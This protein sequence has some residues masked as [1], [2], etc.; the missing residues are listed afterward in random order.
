MSYF[1]LAAR[2]RRLLNGSLKHV[3][4][5]ALAGAL[6]PLGTVA[7]PDSALA[8]PNTSRVDATVTPVGD[9]FR[10]DFTVVNTSEGGVATFGVG[11]GTP[12]IV[13]WELPLFSLDDIDVSSIV[14][15]SGWNFEILTPP[16]DSSQNGTVWTT[17]DADT[18]PLL[19]PLQGGD[20]DLYGPNP[21]VFENPPYV[22]H[23]FNVCCGSGG[24][25]PIF[26]GQFLSGFSFESE[27]SSQNA[28]YMAS[29]STFP[30][31]GGDPPIPG[32]AFGSPNSPAR[33]AAQG[34][35]EP[36]SLVLLVMA[37]SALAISGRHS[38][39][40]GEEG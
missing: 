34:I 27:Y 9:G 4:K 26:P 22:L 12:V 23:W 38:R 17:Y 15:P 11:G 7:L 36:S 8:Q 20:P 10:Y 16:Y 33:M 30:P 32:S 13:D 19:D 31:R 18:D 21:Q 40:D 5:A 3:R 1:E 35:P 29:W 37:G 6:V 14:S 28:P 24:A 39:D 2:S 25:G